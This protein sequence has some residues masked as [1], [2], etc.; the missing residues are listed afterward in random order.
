[1][2]KLFKYVFLT[3]KH[4]VEKLGVVENIFFHQNE[5]IKMHY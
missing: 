4:S 1:M 2:Q 5:P 3:K